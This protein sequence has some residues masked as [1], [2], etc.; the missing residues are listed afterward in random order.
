MD[1]PYRDEELGVYRKLAR[2]IRGGESANTQ[3]IKQKNPELAITRRRNRSGLGP[4]ILVGKLIAKL[5]TSGRLTISVDGKNI[6]ALKVGESRKLELEPGTHLVKF[7]PRGKT[8][9][10]QFLAETGSCTKLWCQVE[11]MKIVLF[12]KFQ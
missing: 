4:T 7:Q 5:M 8:A 2:K 12:D 1:N 10:F 11:P 3:H 9:S 6:G